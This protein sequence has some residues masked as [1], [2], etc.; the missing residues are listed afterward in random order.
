MLQ[1]PE[2]VHQRGDPKYMFSGAHTHRTN[3]PKSDTNVI[4]VFCTCAHLMHIACDTRRD[5]VICD[6]CEL[7]R[8]SF[9]KA[10]MELGT[11]DIGNANEQERERELKG[12][13]HL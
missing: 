9:G 8:L 10:E 2:V 11:V 1:N 6:T 4:D 3:C 13:R 5:A 7:D 12:C